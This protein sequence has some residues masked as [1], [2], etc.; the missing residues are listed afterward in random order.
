MIFSFYILSFFCLLSCGVDAYGPLGYPS[1]TQLGPSNLPCPSCTQNGLPCPVPIGWS[2]QANWN[3]TQSTV[4]QP[5]SE[6]YFMPKH[7]WGLISLDW[8]TAKNVWFTGDN[9]T[10]TC[11][12][13]SVENCRMLK[14]S[15]LVSRCFIYHN[16]LLALQ[17]LESQREV[18]YDPTKKDWF[19]QYTDGQG[20]K[21][22]TIYNEPMAYGDQYFWDF[23]VPAA[24]DYYISSILAVVGDSAVDGTFTDD[25]SGFPEEH[26]SVQN[27]TNMTLS[28]IVDWQYNTRL[29]SQTLINALAHSGKGNWQAFYGFLDWVGPSPN[30]TTCTAFLREF[31]QPSYQGRLMTMDA[32]KDAAE[33]PQIVASFLITRPPVAYLGWG[34]ESDDS[35]WDDIFLLQVGEAQGLCQEETPGV[36]TRQY[37]NGKAQLDCNN[38]KADLPFPSL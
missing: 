10:S 35:L 8:G 18:M 6:D 17:I 2:E 1:C 27:N 30:S 12:K 14:A 31:C 33:H 3:L 9:K 4:I 15:G 5:R 36:F 13:T 21:N 7:P 20:N 16:M 34:W 28:E 29:L 25:I 26:P 19:I 22:G 37:T 11:E 23:R 32:G 38:W 24:R